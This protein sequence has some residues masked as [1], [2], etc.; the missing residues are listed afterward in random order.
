[1]LPDQAA[2]QAYLDSMKDEVA[3]AVRDG[4]ATYSAYPDEDKADATLHPSDDESR[5]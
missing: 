2:G 5:W 3:K 4:I 1:M